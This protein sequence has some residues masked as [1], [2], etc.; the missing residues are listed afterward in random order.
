M[1]FIMKKEMLTSKI[2]TEV[3]TEKPLMETGAVVVD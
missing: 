2:A 1:G 3:A